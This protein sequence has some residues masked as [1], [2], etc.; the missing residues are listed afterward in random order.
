M[1]EIPAGDWFCDPCALGL[2]PKSLACQLC[3]TPGGALLPVADHL[4]R[5]VSEMAYTGGGG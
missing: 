1:Q 3:M 4:K 5:E 2:A